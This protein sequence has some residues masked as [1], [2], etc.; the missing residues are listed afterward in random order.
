MP[1]KVSDVGLTVSG[2][3]TVIVSTG[4]PAAQALENVAEVV[5]SATAATVIVLLPLLSSVNG[6]AGEIVA[7]E[8][9]GPVYVTVAPWQPTPDPVTTTLFE[10]PPITTPTLV[11]A[12]LSI[13]AAS[14]IST[15]SRTMAIAS[16]EAIAR[17]T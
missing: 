5:P 3:F 17:P 12:M 2:P 10:G 7:M 4:F 1:L 16:T 6:D 15:H 13:G 11:G 9:L 8:A 14:A